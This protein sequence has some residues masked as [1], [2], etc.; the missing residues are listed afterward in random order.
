MYVSAW[1]LVLMF[2]AWWAENLWRARRNAQF[3][4]ALGRQLAKAERDRD[5]YLEQL[6]HWS[7]RDD[8]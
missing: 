8:D 7:R 3:Y 2:L 5:Y 6:T 4:A 1:W